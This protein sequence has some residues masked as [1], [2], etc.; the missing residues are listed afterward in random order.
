MKFLFSIVFFAIVAAANSAV[1]QTTKLYPG[2]GFV[3]EEKTIPF[4]SFARFNPYVPVPAVPSVYDA[5]YFRNF[6]PYPY[7][8]H[9]NY[10]GQIVP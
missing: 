10:L 4:A 3:S 6:N 7:E 2:G 5:L 1:L 8:V 9:T